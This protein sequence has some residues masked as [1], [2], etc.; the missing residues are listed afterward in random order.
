[1]KGGAPT[2]IKVSEIFSGKK[3]A[4]IT[5]PG[6]LTPT[7]QDNH[8][9]DWVAA[10]GSLKAKGIDSIVCISVNDAFV[11]DVFEKK[12]E[13]T[14]KIDFYA[15]G[16]AGFVKAAGIDVDTG[17]FGGVR[18]VRGSY[19]VEDGEFTAVNTEDGT[20]YEGAAKP[21]TILA[22]LDAIKA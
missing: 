20:K 7:C 15:D 5:I 14:G 8:V 2:P 22:Q 11:M 10:Y 6:A 19:L 21:E 16:G 1:M 4:L 9:K 3:V 18:A 12:T 17:A 13:A